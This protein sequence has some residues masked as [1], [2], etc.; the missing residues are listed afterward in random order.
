LLSCQS[1]YLIK[2]GQSKSKAAPPR[3]FGIADDHR[4]WLYLSLSPQCLLSPS[5]AWNGSQT[6][7]FCY[8]CLKRDFWIWTSDASKSKYR[9]FHL[10]RFESEGQG[11]TKEA[12][13]PFPLCDQ[14]F[15]MEDGRTKRVLC[16]FPLIQIQNWLFLVESVDAYR[17][18]NNRI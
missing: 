2:N 9:T 6:R 8:C 7:A 10:L 5:M 12:S 18:Q 16:T 17:N 15:I 1:S 4:T 11:D 3:W 13:P 14:I